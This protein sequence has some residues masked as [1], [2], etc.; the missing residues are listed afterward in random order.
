M[1]S[2]ATT[3]SI[4]VTKPTVR[5]TTSSHSHINRFGFSSHA[6]NVNLPSLMKV[7]GGKTTEVSTLQPLSYKLDTKPSDKRLKATAE[8]ILSQPRACSNRLSRV[9]QKATHR[10]PSIPFSNNRLEAPTASLQPES[11]SRT[12]S[13][14]KAIQRATLHKS[15]PPAT[16]ASQHEAV[17]RIAT[18]SLIPIEHPEED[19]DHLGEEDEEDQPITNAFVFSVTQDNDNEPLDKVPASNAVRPNNF[20]SLFPKRDYTDDLSPG[21]EPIQ[22]SCSFGSGAS[23]HK[24]VKVDRV[25]SQKTPHIRHAARKLSLGDADELRRFQDRFHKKSL[26]TP[27]NRGCFE[28][29]ESCSSASASASFTT[30][31]TLF[32]PASAYFNH[33]L[34]CIFFQTSLGHYM[35]VTAHSFFSPTR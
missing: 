5:S 15:C 11:S 9:F 33:Y 26:P 6:L 1:K 22:R 30:G 18:P 2:Q 20:N 27:P 7:D 21:G 16:H 14:G 32:T 24:S 34:L 23:F 35:L 13:L 29:R 12:S 19:S 17:V 8:S 28:Q 10:K 31:I 25:H 4:A 3:D